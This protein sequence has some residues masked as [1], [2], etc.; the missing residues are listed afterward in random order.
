MGVGEPVFLRELSHAP[1]DGPTGTHIRK[2]INRF[3]DS[4]NIKKKRQAH[5]VGRKK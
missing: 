4:V 3:S 2:A 1:T 5:K